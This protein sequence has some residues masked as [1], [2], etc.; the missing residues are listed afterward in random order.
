MAKQLITPK[1]IAE[2][3]QED[4]LYVDKNMILSPNVKDYC[5]ENKITLI[6]G[7]VKSCEEKKYGKKE[8]TQK[9]R[10]TVIEVLEQDFNIHDEKLVELVLKKMEGEIKSWG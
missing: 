10:E 7:E 1:N 5:K 6:Y 4:K 3:L 8:S 2:Y 9:L